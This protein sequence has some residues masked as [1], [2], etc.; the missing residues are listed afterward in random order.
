MNKKEILKRV[1]KEGIEFIRVEHLDYN[2]IIRSR[3]V[4]KRRLKDALD[5]GI[6]MSTAIM[7]FNIFERLIKNPMYGSNA[8]DYFLLP[9]PET[10]MV[11]PYLSNTARMFCDLVDEN[12]KPWQGC[13]RTALLKMVK[14]VEEMDFQ[15]KMAC[16]TEGSLVKKIDNTY[17]PADFHKCFTPDGLDIQD[18]LLQEVVFSLEKMGIL[19]DKMTAEY[20]PGQYEVNLAPSN[21]LKAAE[22]LITYKELWR[23]LA[24]KKGLI[25]TFMP[26]PFKEYAGNGLHVHISLYDSKGEA[27]LF[28][29]KN[30]LQGIGL[31]NLAYYFIGGLL[32][33]ASAI[34]AIG[35]PT[36][37]SYKR[38]LPGHW[39][40]AHI[41]YG[42]GN[43]DVLVRI[44]DGPRTKRLEFRSADASCNPYLAIAAIIAAGIDGIKNEIDPGHPVKE[45]IGSLSREDIEERGIK[46]LPCSLCEAI[47]E[48][49][50][51]TYIQEKLGP[52]LMKEFIRV[53][54]SEFDTFKE[55]VSEK[56]RE[57]YLETY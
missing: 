56:E 17:V 51:D 2:G 37:N 10:F 46:W 12:G 18:E 23:A 25:A 4:R 28:E 27:N 45:A 42:Q 41:C 57:V 50:E 33:H 29:N 14:E 7:S 55:E 21:P 8:G 54:Q 47:S 35:A 24:R 19:V 39:C 22:D 26:K 30:D 53:R 40:P 9:D 11:I 31:S 16:E 48:L 1:D 34:T 43:R 49:K 13:P 32:R 3:S 52:A 20:G 5:K 44:P 6:N 15:L 38:L 36:I